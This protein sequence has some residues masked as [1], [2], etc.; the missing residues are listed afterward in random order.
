MKQDGQGGTGDLTRR[1][2]LARHEGIKARRALATPPRQAQVAGQEQDQ[3][4]CQRQEAREKL[5]ARGSEHV[6]IQKAVAILPGAWEACKAHL[7]LTLALT[8]PRSR[9][10]LRSAFAGSEGECSLYCR[11]PTLPV[12]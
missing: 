3:D 4:H 12:A 10:I 7:S 9:P 8:R 1:A 2:I 5:R 6:L 11:R